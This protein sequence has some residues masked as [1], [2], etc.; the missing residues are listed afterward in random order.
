MYEDDLTK[1]LNKLRG[2]GMHKK[3]CKDHLGNEFESVSAMCN[4][5]EIPLSKFNSRISLGWSLEKALTYKKDKIV[6]H[7]GNEFKSYS[8]LYK[9]YGVDYSFALEK[10]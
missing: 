6:D 1:E 8:S 10:K 4:Y 9:F 7:L 5:Y 2:E 3:P